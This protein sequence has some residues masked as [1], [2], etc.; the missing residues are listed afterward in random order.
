MSEH[1][2][3]ARV[4]HSQQAAFI[5]R[6]FFNYKRLTPMRVPV[7]FSPKG[8]TATAG[9]NTLTLN[10]NTVTVAMGYYIYRG[11]TA[12]QATDAAGFATGTTFYN[13]HSNSPDRAMKRGVDF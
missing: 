12:G 6:T 7:T 2:P 3:L 4:T 8:V 13:P 11:T 10:W 9:P 5:T 1:C